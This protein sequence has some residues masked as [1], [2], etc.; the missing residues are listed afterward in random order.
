MLKAQKE[1][2]MMRMMNQQSICYVGA[3]QVQ[4]LY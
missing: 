4:S 3:V 1:W 2:M